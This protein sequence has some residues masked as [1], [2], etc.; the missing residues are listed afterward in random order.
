MSSLPLTLPC[1]IT[2]LGSVYLVQFVL[3]LKSHGREFGVGVGTTTRT[4]TGLKSRRRRSV[5]DVLFQMDLFFS[6][7]RDHVDIVTFTDR[8][9]R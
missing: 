1:Y 8:T 5:V 4:H 2:S 9:S 3:P 7:P 6:P